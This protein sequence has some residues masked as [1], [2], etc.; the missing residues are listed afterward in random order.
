MK[1]RILF[2]AEI[3]EIISKCCL[4][5]SLTSMLNVNTKQT[6][7]KRVKR[8]A[9]IAFDI[10]KTCLYKFDPIKPHFYTV[11]LWFKWVLHY[12]FFLLEY[13]I[14]FFSYCCSKT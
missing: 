13:Y 4:L 12:F 11:K 9:L 14:I 8:C 3:K 5:K 1:S 6:S 2:S 7:V 10:T